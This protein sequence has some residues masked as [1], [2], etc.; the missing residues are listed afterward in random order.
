MFLRET[1]WALWIKIVRIEIH[2]IDHRFIAALQSRLV[3]VWGDTQYTSLHHVVKWAL[4]SFSATS[5]SGGT[6]DPFSTSYLLK[7]DHKSHFHS[8]LFQYITIFWYISNHGC[9]CLMHYVPVTTNSVRRHGARR[10][11]RRRGGLPLCV[12]INRPVGHEIF[13]LLKD[14]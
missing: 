5:T 6:S 2:W 13:G 7:V 4:T 1:S 11:S 8:I 3:C 9:C 14:I 12:S 10:I